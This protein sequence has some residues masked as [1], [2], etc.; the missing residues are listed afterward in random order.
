MQTFVL[1]IVSAAQVHFDDE[2]RY[3]RVSTPAGNI[4]FE[5]R[6]EPFLSVLK[7]NSEVMYRDAIGA[8]HTLPVESGMLSFRD[9]RCT[10]TVEP[11]VQ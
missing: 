11:R 5:A 10:L 9:N 2:A 4:G 3:C 6:H 8:E 7:E 1:T